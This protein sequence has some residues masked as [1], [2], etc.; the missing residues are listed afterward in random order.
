MAQGKDTEA[1]I[2]DLELRAM[3]GSI[4]NWDCAAERDPKKLANLARA[5]SVLTNLALNGLSD[6]DSIGDLERTIVMECAD[7][8]DLLSFRLARELRALEGLGE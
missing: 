4:L 3:R 5:A 1:T 6:S 8:T 7:L 2:V